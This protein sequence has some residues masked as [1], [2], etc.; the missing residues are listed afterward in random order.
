[1]GPPRSGP[2]DGKIVPAPPPPRSRIPLAMARSPLM[3]AVLRSLRAIRASRA[4]GIPAEEWLATRREA[5]RA[6]AG[7]A[8]ASLLA[9]CALERPA[10][11]DAP[12]RGAGGPKVVV[13]G[14]GIAGL[15]CARRLL[16]LGVVAEVREASGRTGGRM[17][18]DR[19]TFGPQS[20]EFGGE[21]VDTGHL[22]MLD[23]AAELGLELLDF[24]TDDPA[25]APWVAHVGG[26]R[27]TE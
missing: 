16:G 10:E 23:L 25:A 17:F 13:V 26:R 7:L 19:H 8:G 15:H 20:C 1:M 22:T 5:L 9:G 12:P 11:P 27:L 14:G 2:D 21:F 18:T 24:T 3:D 4:T 6:A